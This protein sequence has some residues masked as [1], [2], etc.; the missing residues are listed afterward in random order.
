M[1]YAYEICLWGAL[2]QTKMVLNI[3]TIVK[4]TQNDLLLLGAPAAERDVGMELHC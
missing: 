2:V 1:E 4:D 3:L